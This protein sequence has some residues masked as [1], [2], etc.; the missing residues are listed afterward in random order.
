MHILAV[1]CMTADVFDMFYLIAICVCLI[2]AVDCMTA[3][4][5]DMF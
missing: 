1:D 5:F 2:L 3:D 4:V